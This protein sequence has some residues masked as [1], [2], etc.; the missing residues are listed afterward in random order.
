MVSQPLENV[1]HLNLLRVL[2]LP[3]WSIQ[4][5]NLKSCDSE[6][7]LRLRLQKQ[8]YLL[9]DVIVIFVF[10]CQWKNQIIFYLNS[11]RGSP[12]VLNSGSWCFGKRRCFM[13]SGVKDVS[14]FR[15]IT[16]SPG[17]CIIKL[18][19]F[20]GIKTVVSWNKDTSTKFSCK[21]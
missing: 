19:T 3:I 21:I 18:Y 5:T 12:L 2:I 6:K 20:F 10:K 9:W 16:C 8:Y 17:R 14:H 4:N 1:A 13:V 15:V 7:Y 11:D